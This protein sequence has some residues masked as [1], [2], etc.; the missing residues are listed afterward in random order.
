VYVRSECLRAKCCRLEGPG[1]H[2]LRLPKVTTRRRRLSA[3]VGSR[4]GMES[5]RRALVCMLGLCDVT[6][7]CLVSRGRGLVPVGVVLFQ[8]AWL[9]SL[10]SRPGW[11]CS[12]GLGGSDIFASLMTLG[13]VDA[14]CGLV[15]E[16][17]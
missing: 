15:C 13:F 7:R 12:G 6:V 8:W 4:L 16:R 17:V 5:G 1:Y 3:A 2:N 9:G 10:R 11:V 14:V